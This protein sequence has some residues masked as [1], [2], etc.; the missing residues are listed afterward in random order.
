MT[1]KELRD[2]LDKCDD[3]MNIVIA[4][5]DFHVYLDIEGH[6][7]GII[8]LTSDGSTN[9]YE[10]ESLGREYFCINA[11]LDNWHEATPIEK[12]FPNILNFGD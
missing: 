11:P 7:N 5:Y 12:I 9:G 10:Y 6:E 3:N 2:K 4:N 8:T 1:V